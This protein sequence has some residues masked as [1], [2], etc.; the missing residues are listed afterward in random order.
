ME[1]KDLHKIVIFELR[2]RGRFS[3]G[4]KGIILT[5][6]WIFIWPEGTSEEKISEASKKFDQ[7]CGSGNVRVRGLVCAEDNTIRLSYK[8]N[9]E[10]I[11]DLLIN[12]FGC[13][14]QKFDLYCN[15]TV[16]LGSIIII[17]TIKE[18]VGIYN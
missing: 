12:A 14:K 15:F 5:N 1:V 9:K 18:I 16:Y 17:G 4:D 2:N 8:Y 10:V 6:N 7:E 13:D 11:K 3:Q